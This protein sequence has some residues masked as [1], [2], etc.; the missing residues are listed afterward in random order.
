[1]TGAG[2]Q[3]NNPLWSF[4]MDYPACFG[5]MQYR[6]TEAY[7]DMTEDPNEDAAAQKLRE[8]KIQCAQCAAFEPCSKISL[9]DSIV[10]LNQI[11][12]DMEDYDEEDY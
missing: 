5:D 3:A 9:V 10:V 12:S 11:L 8:I 4:E 6:F 7:E 2:F 1:M